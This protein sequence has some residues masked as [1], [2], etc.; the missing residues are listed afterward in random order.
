MSDLDI[1]HSIFDKTA[2]AATM[3]SLAIP[4]VGPVVA[5]G[6]AGLQSAV[7]IF[8]LMFGGDSS[9][10]PGARLVTQTDLDNAI[11]RI[12]KLVDDGQTWHDIEG[13]FNDIAGWNDMISKNW[14]DTNQSTSPSFYGAFAGPQQAANWH[15]TMSALATPLSIGNDGIMEKLKLLERDTTFAVKTLHIYA[16]GVTTFL[17]L[18]KVNVMWE[19]SDILRAYRIAET[20]WT[21]AQTAASKA[22]ATWSLK[23][24][25]TRGPEPKMPASLV[26]MIDT[27]KIV[28]AS[29]YVA[30]IQ[31]YLPDFIKYTRA[32]KAVI[33][34][35]FDAYANDLATHKAAVSLKHENGAW[36]YED[37]QT[38]AKGTPVSDKTLAQ[39]NMDAY[40]GTLDAGAY[41]RFVT[42]NQADIYDL[43]TLAKVDRT[44]DGWDACLK[45]AVGYLNQ[46]NVKQ[47]PLGGPAPG[48]AG[49]G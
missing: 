40:I 26:A 23:S 5:A 7:D 12:P 27:D 49:N 18:V 37:S 25:D 31:K 9:T 35:Y 43:D 11:N 41:D 24:P 29:T 30:L 14:A 38:G 46:L 10:P 19:Y 22:Y 2:S 13:V 3:G 33:Q 8:F 34:G 15:K 6:V 47:A 21:A 1:V 39:M 48:Q 32:Q 44:C 28:G 20:Q 42:Q 36:H 4:E 17:L 45:D 16:Y